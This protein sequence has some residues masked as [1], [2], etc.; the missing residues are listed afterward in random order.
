MLSKIK[1][2]LL[3]KEFISSEVKFLCSVSGG[4]DSMAMTDALIRLGFH[5]G[6]AHINHKTRAGESDLDHEFVKSYAL[7]NNLQF[8]SAIFK[9]DGKS[10]FQSAGRTFRYQFLHKIAEEHGYD[11]IVT[12]HHQQDANETFLLNL[13][14]G[15]GINGLLGI[16]DRSSRI[17]RPMINVKSSEIEK[18]IRDYKID[19][20]EDS[21]NAEVHY[22]RNRVRHL[23]MPALENLYHDYENGFEVT[24]QNLN[25]TKVLL[26]ELSSSYLSCTVYN[27]ICVKK[28]DLHG[29]QSIKNLLFYL[30]FPYG[31]NWEQISNL[32]NSDLGAAVETMRFILVHDRESFTLM[33]KDF[34][35]VV[36]DVQSEGEYKLKDG[37]ILS[38]RKTKAGEGI[39]FIGD[40]FPLIIRSRKAGDKFKPQ[41]MHGQTKSLKKFLTDEKISFEAK[42]YLLLVEKDQQIK[43]IVDGRVAHEDE[44]PT[45]FLKVTFN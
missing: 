24:I 9:F 36:M 37:R 32:Y 1:E 43:G 5:I 45:H 16:S 6:I 4:K 34:S 12:A 3:E 7:N 29:F 14:R 21:S 35:E 33:K 8:F 20:K 27:N 11:F 22:Q 10:N 39:P 15:T 23:V 30:F 18:Y 31:F 13:C 28:S 19:F 42:R 25:R 2:N 41:G 26:D 44:S 17:V 38:V 40:P